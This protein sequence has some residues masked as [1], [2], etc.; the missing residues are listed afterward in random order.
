MPIIPIRLFLSVDWSANR[1]YHLRMQEAAMR[2]YLAMIL[3]F[4][5]NLGTVAPSSAQEAGVSELLKTSDEM[6]QSAIRLRGL[7]PTGPIQKG[8]KDK[9]EISR[10]LNNRVQEEYSKE[11]IEREGKIL[12]ILGL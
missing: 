9:E 5:I 8:V 2:H 1:H 12:K 11:E 10:Y 4:V 7:E 6:L 3:V